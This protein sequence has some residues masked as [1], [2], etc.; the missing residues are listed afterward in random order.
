[1]NELV[2]VADGSAWG[3]TDED[4]AVADPPKGRVTS[5]AGTAPMTPASFGD[6]R[7]QVRARFGVPQLIRCCPGAGCGSSC[8]P[9]VAELR[10]VVLLG[11]EVDL[12]AR[13]WICQIRPE[14]PN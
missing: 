5:H 8:S 3:D 10:P 6:Q 2:F 13:I 1:M 12:E 14:M 9:G 7:K 11:P 4:W